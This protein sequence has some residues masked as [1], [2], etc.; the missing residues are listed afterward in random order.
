MLLLPVFQLHFTFK[1]HIT[2][3]VVSEQIAYFSVLQIK[4]N[5]KKKSIV[6]DVTGYKLL[7]Q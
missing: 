1:S 3:L 2:K 4:L 7:R 5:F 6:C